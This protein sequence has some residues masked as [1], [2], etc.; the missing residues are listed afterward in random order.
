MDCSN[1]SAWYNRQPGTDDPY[2]HVVGTC[3]LPSGSLRLEL[4]PG[5]EGVVDEPD[6]FVLQLV[7]RKP[8]IGDAMVIDRQ[9]TWEGNA[10]PDIRR[11]RIQG[12]AEAMIEVVEATSVDRTPR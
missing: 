11:V 12:E 3:T 2:L 1:W 8:E 5:D 10:G 7:T 6:L 4:V 9:V